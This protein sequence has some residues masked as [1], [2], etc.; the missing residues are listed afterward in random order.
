MHWDLKCGNIVLDQ[1]YH[2][3]LIDFATCKILENPLINAKIAAFNTR[4]CPTPH[5]CEMLN[6]VNSLVGTEE[7]LAPET[8]CD[9]HL[10]YTCDYWSLG[11]IL[12][13]MLCG[14]TPFKGQTN[15]ET[16]KNIQNLKEIK[17]PDNL[18]I[19]PNAK[20]LTEQLLSKD[21]LKRLG[22]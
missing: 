17:F 1:N 6:R 13:E 5:N 20:D 11:I 7:Y 2:I 18:K 12:Y 14:Y 15:E 10:S 3:K 8:I 9:G 22:F 16:I 4:N 21:P 19:D